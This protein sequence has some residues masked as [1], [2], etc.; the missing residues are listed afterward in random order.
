MP[1]S[2]PRILLSWVYHISFALIL[3]IGALG[4]LYELIGPKKVEE[5]LLSIGISL[6]IPQYWAISGVCLAFFIGSNIIRNK[7]NFYPKE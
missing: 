5:L 7:M 2:V 6:S 4:V 1:K 3:L